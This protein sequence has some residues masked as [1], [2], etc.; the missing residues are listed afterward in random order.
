MCPAW[1][2][3]LTVDFWLHEENN[4]VQF[5]FNPGEPITI[6][7]FKKKNEDMVAKGSWSTT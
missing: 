5:V 1:E 7:S 3:S 6:V 2:M 4:L